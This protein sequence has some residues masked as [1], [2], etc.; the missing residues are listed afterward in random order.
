MIGLC[1]SA[2]WFRRYESPTVRAGS[3]GTLRARRSSR[4]LRLGNSSARQRFL[5]E[6]PARNPVTRQAEFAGTALNLV[7][8][9]G[10]QRAEGQP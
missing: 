3:V 10:D 8:S 1:C 5:T 6:R 4:G 7:R 9:T 2:I